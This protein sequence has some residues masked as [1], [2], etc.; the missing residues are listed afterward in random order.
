MCL[1]V[2]SFA[3]QDRIWS[4]FY[5]FRKVVVLRY[6]YFVTFDRVIANEVTPTWLPF[7]TKINK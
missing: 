2:Q 7:T 6:V 5:V 4:C 3:C 1:A